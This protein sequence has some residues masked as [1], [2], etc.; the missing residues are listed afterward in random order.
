MATLRR[1]TVLALLAIAFDG[2]ELLGPAAAQAPAVV[3]L[4]SISTFG[5]NTSV[6][7]PDR[8]SVSL[9]GVGRSSMG[10]TA[11]GSGLFPGNR[12][13][14]RNLSSSR[15]SVRATVQDLDALD[16]A[17]LE[18]ASA[19]RE[20]QRSAAEA[21]LAKRRLAIVRQSSAG[22]VP[23]SSVAEA[24]RQRAADLAGQQ[25]E[26][27]QNIKRARDAA[28]VG[29]PRVAAMFYQLAAKQATGEL[30]LQIDKEA[31]AAARNSA[32]SRVAQTGRTS[33]R[34]RRP[35]PH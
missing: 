28:Q 30:K 10:S 31:A 5:V 3:Q 12:S 21:Y 26:A 25:A 27:V 14:G 22:Q 18:R 34:Q 7:A 6:S 11:Y 1:L 9:G 13:F 24:R 35:L 23:P 19:G 8:G 16:R 29:K 15:T 4:P 20:S 32:A 2:A 33:A 17:T